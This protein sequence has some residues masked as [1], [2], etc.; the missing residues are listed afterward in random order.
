MHQAVCEEFLHFSKGVLELVGDSQKF[1]QSEKSASDARVVAV[2]ALHV[3]E[4]DEG[5]L[6][7]QRRQPFLL[8]PVLG[9]RSLIE[10]LVLSPVFFVYGFNRLDAVS[11]GHHLQIVISRVYA[12]LNGVAEHAQRPGRQISCLEKV[13][14][15]ANGCVQNI[16]V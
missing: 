8:D 11:H 7:L 3:S 12:V 14:V 6:G 13:F 15:Q 4:L 10:G 2:Y 9:R 5:P 16:C 1:S